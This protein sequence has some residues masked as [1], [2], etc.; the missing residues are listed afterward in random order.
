MVLRLLFN[1]W[2]DDVGVVDVPPS[3]PPNELYP[4]HLPYPPRQST[5]LGTL[6]QTLTT[7]PPLRH[8]LA[9]AHDAA[10]RHTLANAHD[11]AAAPDARDPPAHHTALATQPRATPLVATLPLATRPLA[12]QS[13]HAVARDA[14]DQSLPSLPTGRMHGA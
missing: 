10:A 6:S 8:T 7:P 11:A 9:N 5:K 14:P 1:T 4:P 2:V 3:H 12:T 13:R